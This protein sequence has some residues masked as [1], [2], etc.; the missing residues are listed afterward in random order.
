MTGIPKCAPQPIKLR[1][2]K[3]AQ[4]KHKNPIDPIRKENAYSEP[5]ANQTHTDYLYANT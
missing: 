2:D 1:G 3:T 4:D 5:P